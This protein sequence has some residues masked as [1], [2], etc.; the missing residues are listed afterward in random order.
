MKPEDKLPRKRFANSENAKPMRHLT[1]AEKIIM[2]EVFEGFI[3]G[4]SQIKKAQDQARD[5]AIDLPTWQINRLLG[6][7]FTK[8]EISAINKLTD[9]WTV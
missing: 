5:L 2:L 9:I 8:E 3:S 4:V 1:K 6:E 7:R